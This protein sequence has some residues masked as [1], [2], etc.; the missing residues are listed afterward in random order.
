MQA[1]MT[2]LLS[3]R[4]IKVETFSDGWIWLETFD[5]NGENQHAIALTPSEALQLSDHL[6][7]QARSL[8]INREFA[9]IGP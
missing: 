7:E 4:K 6:R 1:E 3:D 5:A 9:R 2:T 8:I